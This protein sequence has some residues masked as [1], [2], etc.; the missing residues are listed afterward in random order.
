VRL[1]DSQRYVQLATAGLSLFDAARDVAA[2]RSDW[3]PLLGWL[4]RR[5]SSAASGHA[6]PEATV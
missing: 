3:V 1:R 2:H 4:L 5:P 6:A